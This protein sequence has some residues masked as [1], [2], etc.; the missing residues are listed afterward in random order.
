[1]A[2]FTLEIRC[3]NA[4]F[5]DDPHAEVA[6]I[7]AL[8]SGRLSNGTNSGNAYDANGNTVGGFVLTLGAE[9]MN[10]HPIPDAMEAAQ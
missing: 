2:K 5:A 7:L 4:A 10:G 8:V 3:D 1:M 9:N 6:R